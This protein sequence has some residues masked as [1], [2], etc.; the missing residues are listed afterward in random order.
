M[1]DELNKLAT[2]HAE[3]VIPLTGTQY[4]MIHA[5]LSHSQA[6]GFS[7]VVRKPLIG[8]LPKLEEDRKKVRNNWLHVTILLLVETAKE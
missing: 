7:D 1:G 4:I 2:L 8:L 3:K 5:V 6:E